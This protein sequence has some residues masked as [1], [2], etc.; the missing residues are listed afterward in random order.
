MKRS[1]PK[2]KCD[3][4]LVFAKEWITVQVESLTGDRGQ[5]NHKLAE[6]VRSGKTFTETFGF[7]ESD[8]KTMSEGDHEKEKN[9]QEAARALSETRRGNPGLAEAHNIVF[10]DFFGDQKCLENA[11]CTSFSME[12]KRQGVLSYPGTQDDQGV[13]T[14][15]EK[16]RSVGLFSASCQRV[17]V[18]DVRSVMTLLT[19]TVIT[20]GSCLSQ[21]HVVLEKVSNLPWSKMVSCLQERV[22]ELRRQLKG[23]AM[24]KY[25]SI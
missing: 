16:E 18:I 22:D 19:K 23:P 25:H 3:V 5:G 10:K 1:N 20:M 11:S 17:D 21:E 4:S 24:V 13:G 7:M 6:V 8:A 15:S 9:A 12:S 14:N 2:V